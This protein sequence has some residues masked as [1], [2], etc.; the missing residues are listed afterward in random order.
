M[1]KSTFSERLKEAMKIR[2]L[3]SSQIEKISEKL[4]NEQKIKRIIKMP[5]ITDYLKGRYE[6]AQSNIYA[7]ALI[8]DVNEVWLMGEDVPMD[9]S[10]GRTKVTE[11]NVI[12]LATNEVIQKIPYLY[13]TDI[14]EDDPNNFFA[15]YASDSSMAPLLDVGDIAIIRKFDK[16][17]NMK[18]YLLKIKQGNPIIRKVI[19]SDDGKIELQAMNMWNFPTQTDLTLNDI[20]ILGEVVRVEN[21]SAFK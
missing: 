21:R 20:E 1:I 12:N 16:F 11:I 7:L 17:I 6:A 10:Y 4:Y 3:K 13:R 8:L 15:I 9:R 18:T 19:Q 5:V 14:A 2:N